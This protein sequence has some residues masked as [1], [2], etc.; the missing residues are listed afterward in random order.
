MAGPSRCGAPL[1]AL[2]NPQ[3]PTTWSMRARLLSGRNA[4]FP[5]GTSPPGSGDTPL[6]SNLFTLIVW[7]KDRERQYGLRHLKATY[8]GFFL[9]CTAY[10]A[11]KGNCKNPIPWR[12]ILA[13]FM[14]RS[15]FN[16]LLNQIAPG[17]DDVWLRIRSTTAIEVGMSLGKPEYL[18]DFA[19]ERVSK[20]DVDLPAPKIELPKS[21]PASEPTPTKPANPYPGMP[22]NG[23]HTGTF[24]FELRGNQ[25]RATSLKSFLLRAL[26]C[27]ECEVPGTLEKLAGVKNQTKRIVAR[28][29]KALFQGQ[30]QLFIEKHSVDLRNGF[31]AGTNNSEPEVMNWLR[32]AVEEADLKWGIDF[33]GPI[34]EA[35]VL[36]LEELG[37]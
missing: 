5:N 26:Y 17:R 37:L 34:R 20:L 16:S 10:K 22:A 21:S 8:K 1:N 36:T 19:R 27:I 33:K 4:L 2:L 31:Y 3:G 15:Q 7:G 14:K 28:E 12:T 18:I 30:N 32:K 25:V 9:D 13:A 29:P 35:K 24:T 11:Y 6:I 23:R